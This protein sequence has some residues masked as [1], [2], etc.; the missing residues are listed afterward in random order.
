M[1]HAQG[2]QRTRVLPCD[3]RRV[4][5]VVHVPEALADLLH[6][7]TVAARIERVQRESV[8]RRIRQQPGLFGAP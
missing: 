4:H 7:S 8:A 1:W 3:P 2:F 6:P 5:E